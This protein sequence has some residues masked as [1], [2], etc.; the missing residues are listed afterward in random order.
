MTRPKIDILFLKIALKNAVLDEAQCER[1]VRVQAQSAAAGRR[2]PMARLCLDEGLLDESQIAKILRGERYM[3][4]RAADKHL[5]SI[6]EGM[7]LATREQLDE[8]LVDQRFAF[9]E[10]SSGDFP[11]LN[12][13]LRDKGIVTEKQMEDALRLHEVTRDPS[14]RL[15][16]AEVLDALKGVQRPPTHS[17]EFLTEVLAEF[18]IDRKAAEA[19][20]QQE[21]EIYAECPKCARSNLRSSS[22][23]K[24]CGAE[25]AGS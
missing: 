10:R 1:M 25:L 23:C 5:A 16:I 9:K 7:G 11:R 20:Y 15:S 13:I 24:R 12:D 18:G 4:V 6:Y 21:I 19:K 8:C 22:A 3:E 14:R 2:V 17:G